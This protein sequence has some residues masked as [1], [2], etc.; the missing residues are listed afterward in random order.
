MTT[1]DPTARITR[2][3]AV[4]DLAAL[5]D[6]SGPFLTV[7]LPAP[8]G[9]ADSAHRLSVRW[10]NVRRE[11]A[12]RWDADLLAELDDQVERLDHADAEAFVAVQRADG[13]LLVEELHL[14]L[15]APRA[16]VGPAPRLVEIIEHRQR[17]LPHLLVD[18]DRTGATISAFD[19]GRVVA[20]REAEGE[21]LHVHRGAP[22]GWSQRR[23]QQRAENTWEQN[24]DDVA[25]VIGQ[26]AIDVDPMLIAVAGDVR[27]RHLV[28]DALP[29]ALASLAV[30]IGAGDADGIV[31]EVMRSLG[32]LHARMQLDVLDQLRSTGGVTDAAEVEIALSEG[33]VS[34]LVVTGDPDHAAGVDQAVVGALATS[35]DIVVVPSVREVATDGLAAIPRW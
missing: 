14:G 8:S 33:R 23:F 31:D 21:T 20:R 18:T 4:A 7:L 15:D 6:G 24:A 3:Y 35:A 34:T 28:L 27:A 10:R 22:G 11:A 16:L 5:V 25:D 17:T 9:Q 32:D 29:P 26:V 30:E 12:E 2:T 13:R 1:I 19:G